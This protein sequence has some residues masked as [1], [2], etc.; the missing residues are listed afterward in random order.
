MLAPILSTLIM[1]YVIGAV[2]VTIVDDTFH[3]H[4]P[5]EGRYF[6]DAPYWPYHLLRWAWRGALE[7]VARHGSTR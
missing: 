6:G 7:S 5:Y 4:N 2:F 3:N 1:I